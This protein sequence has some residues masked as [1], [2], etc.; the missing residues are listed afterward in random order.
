VAGNTTFTEAH[1]TLTASGSATAKIIIQWNGQDDKPI[2]NFSGTAADNEAGITL[3]GASHIVIDG[4]DIRNPDGLLEFGILLTNAD[5]VTGSQSNLIQN[6]HI[7]LNKN[8]SNQTNGIRVFT[9]HEQTSHTGSN[10]N[11]SFLNNHI[12]NTLL[13]YVLNSNTGT[14]ELMDTGNLVGST[15][16]GEHII[17]DIVFSGVYLLNQN[18][19]TVN[20]VTIRNLFRPNDG[21]ST[22]PAAISTTGSLPSGELTN[23]MVIS[24]NRIEDQYTDGTTI[25]G[26]YLNQRNVHN[27]VYNNVLHNILTEGGGNTYASGIFLFAT[28]STADIYNNMISDIAA[29]LSTGNI[30]SGIYVRLFVAAN[31]YY[32]SVQL[33]YVSGA[34][35]NRSAALYIHNASN[36]VEMR[37]NI[38]VNKS[39]FTAPGNGYAA[40]FYKNTASLSNISSDTDNNIYYAGTPSVNNL[41]FAGG[42]DHDQT[43][44]AYK[45]RAATFDQGSFTEDV[46]F[47]TGNDLYVDPLATTVVRENAQPVSTPIVIDTDIDGKLRD[48][49]NPDIGAAELPNPYPLA[50]SNPQPETQQQDVPVTLQYLQWEYHPDPYHVNPAGFRVYLGT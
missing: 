38:F 23:S 28:G 41:I 17:E 4:L 32:N 14:V 39:G 25:F 35:T 45:T 19:A 16:D 43:L 47:I 22:A 27:E 50:A 31:I 12:T 2:V 21:T 40:A 3:E 44:A 1:L 9:L 29:P 46:P 15:E 48:P 26:M 11:N 20:G 13:G 42:S 49:E 18:G 7:T 37:N 36:P 8:N 10:S 34:G 33:Q 30:S 5:A 6:T 24:N